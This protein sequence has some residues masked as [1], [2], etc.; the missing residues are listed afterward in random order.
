M[1]KDG[2][3][4]R[5]WLKGSVGDKINALLCG[6]GHNMRIILRKL[7]ELFPFFFFFSCLRK[8]TESI[9]GYQAE[10][11]VL[12]A[13]ENGLFQNRRV[14]IRHKN[15][16]I[17]KEVYLAISVKLDDLKEVLGMWTAETEGAKFWL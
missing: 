3:L 12:S 16:V 14:K 10:G 8:I 11:K 5:N 9:F 7:R 1:K 2:K 15:R 4:G 17:N 6:A 13:A